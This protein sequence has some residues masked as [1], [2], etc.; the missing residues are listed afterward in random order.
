VH[1]GDYGIAVLWNVILYMLVGWFQH[2]TH[3]QCFMSHTEMWNMFPLQ[4]IKNKPYK[5][6]QERKVTFLNMGSTSILALLFKF[7]Y[8]NLFLRNIKSVF[9][10]FQNRIF[11]YTHCSDMTP[12]HV[13]PSTGNSLNSSEVEYWLCRWTYMAIYFCPTI[14]WITSLPSVSRLSRKCRLLDIL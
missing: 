1:V 3:I 11:I 4:C 6:K 5:G 9:N 13:R 10:F 2:F 8:N 14:W 12:F 7:S